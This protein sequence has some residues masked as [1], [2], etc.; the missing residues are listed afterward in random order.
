[1]Q[2]EKLVRMANQ[3]AANFDYGPDKQ[4][5]VAGVVDHLQRF[6]SPLMRQEIAGYDDSGD[7]QLSEV[8]KQAVVK[9]AQAQLSVGR[10][11]TQ[12]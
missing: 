1:M 8:A 5:A 6:W 4:K 7:I 9:M 12:N 10:T 11:S 3:I 2:V